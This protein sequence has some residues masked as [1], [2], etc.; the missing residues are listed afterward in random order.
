MKDETLNKLDK[1]LDNEVLPIVEKKDASI[2]T[3]GAA[4][5]GFIAGKALIHKERGK[6]LIDEIE[7]DSTE[8]A[9]IID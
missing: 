3:R 2:Y 9:E 1:L 5:L 8:Y 6:N 4:L 7:N